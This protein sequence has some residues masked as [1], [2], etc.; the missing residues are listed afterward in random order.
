MAKII[1]LLGANGQVGFE[2]QQT[3][4]ALGN[5]VGLGREQADFCRPESLRR[6][7]RQYQPNIIVNAAAY[8]AVDK[9]ESE[10]DV[11]LAVNASAPRVLA[12]EAQALGAALVHYSTDY[13]FDGQKTSLYTEAD[14]P[15]PQ[16]VYGRSKLAGEQAVAN[17]CQRHLIFRTCWVV[18]QHGG[19]FLKTMLRL[20]AERDSL[21]IVADQIGAPTS[22]TLIADI[23]AKVLKAMRGAES[24]D[25]RWGLYHLAAGG[26]T[27]WHGYAQYVISQ[28]RARGCVLK[29]TPEAV[30]P[31]TTADYPLPAARPAN[32]R[33]DTTKL[34]QT[35]ALDLP[36]WQVGVDKVLSAVINQQNQKAEQQ[37]VSKI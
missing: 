33:L 21:R 20:A 35:F 4:V 36:D 22:A 14:T 34:R 7:V 10:V 26:E 29:A 27:S 31:I 17:A 37:W 32:S 2:L 13:V 15:N 5:V 3:L 25:A 9:A 1:L 6:I 16:S 18:G 30:A 12:E 11:A 23:T 8:T 28:A 24:N 19:N